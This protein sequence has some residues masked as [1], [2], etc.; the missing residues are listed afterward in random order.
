MDE[1][2]IPAASCIVT[3]LSKKLCGGRVVSGLQS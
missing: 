3:K 2:A 1:P